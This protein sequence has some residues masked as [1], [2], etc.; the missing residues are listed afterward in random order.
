MLE[1]GLTKNVDVIRGRGVYL[2]NSE[3]LP[4]FLV[5]A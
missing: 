3:K 2:E 5:E 1:H 4:P